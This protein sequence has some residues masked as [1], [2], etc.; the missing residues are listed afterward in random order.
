M[1]EAGDRLVVVNDRQENLLVAASE[2]H[3]R[4][5]EVV[6]RLIDASGDGA[7]P[8]HGELRRGHVEL[9]GAGVG[10]SASVRQQLLGQVDGTHFPH[11][12]A[13]QTKVVT[14][15]WG[16]RTVGRQ[17]RQNVAQNRARPSNVTR[18]GMGLRRERCATHSKKRGRVTSG[19]IPH[20]F[21]H[22]RPVRLHVLGS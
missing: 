4:A 5:L 14:G 16:Q 17:Q 20:H 12:T 9:P 8:G 2:R 22:P 6:K 19:Q 10:Q 7:Q 13:G 21:G 11:R 3:T 18:E 15:Y 1:L